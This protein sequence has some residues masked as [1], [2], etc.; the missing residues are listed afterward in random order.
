MSHD[1]AY[2]V[3]QILEEIVRGAMGYFPTGIP[4]TTNQKVADRIDRM[5]EAEFEKRMKPLR[6]ELAAIK[7][8]ERT[9]TE[10]GVFE[11]M[12]P[13]YELTDDERASALEYFGDDDD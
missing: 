11:E 13:W 12:V 9:Y 2:K 3:A 6:R 7:R 8:R 4:T 5:Y 10:N 1:V